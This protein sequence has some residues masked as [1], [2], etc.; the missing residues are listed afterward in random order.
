T[1]GTIL[2]ALFTAASAQQPARRCPD[3]Y[4]PERW[5][6]ACRVHDEAIVID[7][8]S[9]TT[10][11]ILDEDF[12][13]SK[14]GDDGHFDLPRAAEGGLDAQFY[15]IYV[16]SRYFGTEDLTSEASL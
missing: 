14:R 12:D 8:H 1:G 16:A 11:R 13:I 4:D 15:A 2:F 10:S 3:G 9:D 7:T 6:L 5:A